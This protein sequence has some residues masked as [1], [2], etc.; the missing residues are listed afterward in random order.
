MKVNKVLIDSEA[1]DL[2]KSGITVEKKSPYKRV[3]K[4]VIS[5]FMLG[6]L[7]FA[8]TGCNRG[9]VDLKYGQN[10]ALFIGDDTALVFDVKDWKDYEGEQYQIRTKNGLVLLSASFDT[11]LFPG[12]SEKHSARNFAKNS[13]SENGEVHDY[14]SGTNNPTF[15]YELLDLNWKFNKAALFNKNKAIVFNIKNWRDYEGEQ[16][17]IETD[18]GMYALLSSYNSKLFYDLQSDVKTEDFT[19]KYVGSDGKVTVLGNPIDPKNFNY[20]LLDLKYNFNKIIIFKDKKAVILPVEQWRDYEGEQLQIKV[21]G[22]GII[23]TAAYDSILIDDTNSKTKANDIANNIADEVLDLTKGKEL[24]SG[25]LNKQI[26]D[27]VYGFSNG[28]ISNDNSAT[29]IPI[30]GWCDYEGEQLQVVFPNGDVMLTSSIFLDMIDEGTSTINAN[31]LVDYYSNDKKIYNAKDLTKDSKFNKQ[32]LDFNYGFNYALHV[33]NGNVTIIP[34]KRWKDYYNSSGHSSYNYSENPDGTRHVVVTDDEGS[35]N[36][37]QLQLEL[38]DGTV[39]LTSA[40]DTILLK[41]N[42]IEKYAEMFRGSDGIT[43]NLTPVFG[44]PNVSGWNWRLFDTKW[45]FNYGIYNNGQNSQIFKIRKWMDYK[46]GEQVQL[47][48]HDD[49]VLLTSYINTSL[50]Y[51]KDEQKVEA[52]A[53]AFAGAEKQKGKVYK[54]YN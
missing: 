48:F 52:I 28:V 31:T 51:S 34:L 26:F 36:C 45:T 19:K 15:N 16:L 11:D 25:F 43:T 32:I 39:I 23:V 37:E 3:V 44:E 4:K 13:I 14:S 41:T 5:F 53:K 18:D 7:L 24:S 2:I 50:V 49:S 8:L 6:S 27:F 20:K 29:S 21:L 35:P 40:Y 42:N 30:D 22:G 46:D 54:Y 1:K 10:T 33:E 47:Y 17:Q 38:P 12:E 9:Y